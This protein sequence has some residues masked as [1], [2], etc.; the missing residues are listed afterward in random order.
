MRARVREVL[1]QMENSPKVFSEEHIASSEAFLET[2]EKNILKAKEFV[3]GSFQNS[4]PV[5]QEL[6]RDSTR[7]SSRKVLKWVKEGVKPTFE[8]V[9]N[10][11][12]AKLNRVRG[13][14]RH[15]VPKGQVEAYLK[16]EIPH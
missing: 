9:V 1:D 11:E 6:L 3:A 12:Q 14:L 15:A 7:Q 5:W 8:G 2:I 13:L 10:N 4:Y 16:G